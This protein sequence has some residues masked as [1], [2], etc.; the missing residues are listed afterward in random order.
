MYQGFKVCVLGRTGRHLDAGIFLRANKDFLT[1]GPPTPFKGL[2]C[3][4]GEHRPTKKRVQN[5][6]DASI[7]YP[8][9]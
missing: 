9:V 2:V 1:R 4:F 6:K 8:F 7:I 3:N 5:N